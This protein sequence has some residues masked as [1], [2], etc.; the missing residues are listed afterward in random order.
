MQT[1]QTS[2]EFCLNKMT[3]YSCKKIKFIH[4]IMA[5]THWKQPKS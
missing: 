3:K 2:N 5:I 1:T 4:M